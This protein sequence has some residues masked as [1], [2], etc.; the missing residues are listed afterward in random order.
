MSLGQI[1][2]HRLTHIYNKKDMDDLWYLTFMFSD[3][4]ISPQKGTYK[5]EPSEETE[6]KAALSPLTDLHQLQFH[7][8]APDNF[9]RYLSLHWRDTA[10]RLIVNKE[11]E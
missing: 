2:N 1:T 6:V 4:S 5:K 11:G 7:V 3:G 10:E 9:L 8:D